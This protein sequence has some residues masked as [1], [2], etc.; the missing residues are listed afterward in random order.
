MS[1]ALCRAPQAWT[2]ATEL[3]ISSLIPVAVLLAARGSG[4]LVALTL[5]A[6]LTGQLSQYGIHFALGVLIAKYYREL[7]AWLSARQGFGIAIL[8]LGLLFYMWHYTVP[9]FLRHEIAIVSG[10]GSALILVFLIGSPGVQRML[11]APWIRHIGR[12][13][14]SIYLIHFAI[15]MRL[16]P[17][18]LSSLHSAS[19]HV[20]Y[21]SGLLFTL[22]LTL[23]GAW[24]FY[25]FVEVP[26]IY[27]GK[28]SAAW[29]SPAPAEHTA[30]ARS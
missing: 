21:G 9:P 1:T 22:V 5:T 19:P 20:A 26:S 29:F 17:R 12:T 10:V 6:V 23:V 14:Y 27:I 28:R 3:I 11:S 13:S 25:R 8:L 18:F 16:T 24:I 30:R 4:W 7:H 2:L 15:L